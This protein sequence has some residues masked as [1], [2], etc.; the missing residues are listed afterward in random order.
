MHEKI[1]NIDHN[2]HDTCR[3]LHMNQLYSDKGEVGSR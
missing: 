3:G 2:D 1:S